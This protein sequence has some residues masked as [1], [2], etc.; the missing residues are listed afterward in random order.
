MARR[1]LI[2]VAPLLLIGHPALAGEY[3]FCL[4][5][6]RVASAGLLKDYSNTQIENGLCM[7]SKEV[8]SAIGVSN[9]YKQDI[10]MQ[11]AEYMMREF[12]NRFPKRN[13]KEVIGKC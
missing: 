3:T 1:L 8:V 2:C 11:S 5:I 10:C 12:K 7:T 6:N 4:Q 9:S 13:P